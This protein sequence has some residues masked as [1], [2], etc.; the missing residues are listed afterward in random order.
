MKTKTFIVMA[1][2]VVLAAC[3]GKN[4]Y[5]VVNNSDSFN[6]TSITADSIA[7]VTEKLVKTA[8][9]HIKVNNVQQTGDSIA[10][11]TAAYNGMVMHHQMNNDILNTHDI[12]LSED[13]VMRIY[14][15][16]T[17]A[18][19]TIKIPSQKMEDFMN[20]ISH[21][22]MYVASRTMDIEDKTLDYLSARLKFDNRKE[23]VAQ[24]K[25][26]KITIKDP[27]G[28][29]WLKDDMV[30]EQ[31]NNQKINYAVKYSI[32]SLDFFQSN[33]IVKERIANDDPSAYHLPFFQRL[34][35][36]ISNGWVIFTEIIL[37]LINLWVVILAG[38]GIWL[39]YKTYKIK[40]KNNLA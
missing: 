25:S 20:K 5:E 29:L 32:I 7:D 22:G 9:I 3:K 28:V 8:D 13:S 26:G 4:G 27:A 11:L 10:A 24:Q 38:V 23:L 17:T 31:I 12:K 21:M 30:D 33:T 2:I 15:F 40:Y 18:N 34:T 35:T 1:C 6:K 39:L 19:M 37:T 16:N 14:A 36:A